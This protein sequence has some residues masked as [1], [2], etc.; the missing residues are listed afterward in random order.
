ME[1]V[2]PCTLSKTEPH[3]ITVKKD[4]TFIINFHNIRKKWK[5]KIGFRR[6]KM[7]DNLSNRDHDHA[8]SRAKYQRDR[9]RGCLTLTIYKPPQILRGRENGTPERDLNLSTRRRRQIVQTAAQHVVREVFWGNDQS[10]VSGSE[11][12][13]LHSASS[14]RG[15]QEGCG[16]NWW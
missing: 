7:R 9:L 8:Q 12:H 15:P 13:L 5:M 11:S 3:W 14:I 2:G 6:S 4:N 16:W 10:F 1:N